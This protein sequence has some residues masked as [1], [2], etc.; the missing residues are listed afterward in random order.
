MGHVIA[1]CAWN[2]SAERISTGGKTLIQ[3]AGLSETP[4]WNFLGWSSVLAEWLSILRQSIHQQSS[5][6]IALLPYNGRRS[7]QIP[8]PQSFLRPPTS[9]PPKPCH[10]LVRTRVDKD[11]MAQGKRGTAVGREDGDIGEEK[12][13][14][15]SHK[16]TADILCTLNAR[17][18]QSSRAC[19]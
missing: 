13:S 14:C 18:I 16:S 9:P 2:A 7:R 3:L 15:C 11:D 6:A 17:I 5:R 10:L 12:H 1:R 19:N 8:L 4:W